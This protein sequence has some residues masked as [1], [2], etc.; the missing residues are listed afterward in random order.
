M[1]RC[2]RCGEDVAPLDAVGCPACSVPLHPACA[3]GGCPMR[4]CSEFTLWSPGPITQRL[5][6]KL[7]GAGFA[8]VL[9]AVLFRAVGRETP[10]LLPGL[11]GARLLSEARALHARAGSEPRPLRADELGS[12]PYVQHVARGGA[13]V[14]DGALVLHLG[15]GPEAAAVV[16]IAPDDRGG[17]REPSTAELDALDPRPA[18]VFGHF[19]RYDD[20]AYIHLFSFR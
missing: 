15:L 18:G 19:E 1:L 9:L 11:D 4:A 10:G 20:G 13:S 8:A 12:A 2:A 16:V 14:R 6:G 7:L 3:R 17:Y 5:L